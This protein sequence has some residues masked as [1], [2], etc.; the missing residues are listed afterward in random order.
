MSNRSND[1]YQQIQN[2]MAKME[3]DIRSLSQQSL[4]LPVVDAD[5][6]VDQGNA[7]LM[8]DGRLRVRTAS[9]TIKEYAPVGTAGGTTTTIPKPAPPAAKK[10]YV[11][12]WDATWTQAYNDSG[13]QRTDYGDQLV[14]GWGDSYNGKNT[15]LI[16]FDYAAIRTALLGS[17]VTKVELNF[18][19]LYA[20]WNWGAYVRFGVHTNTAK[21]GTYGGVIRN[22]L[23]QVTYGKPEA[24]WATIA[25]EFGIRFRD[26]T[27]RG[28]SIDPLTTDKAFYGRAAGITGQGIAPQIRITYVK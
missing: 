7:W 12:H 3:E 21:P 16:G 17:S 27:G 13:G 25:T 24:K 5:P 19:Q 8:N 20:W 26:G 6:D 14:Y 15:S 9:G 18:N 28:I 23:T 22:N 1:P 4:R 2:R 11:N 10:T